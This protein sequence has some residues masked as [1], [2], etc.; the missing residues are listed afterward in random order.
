MTLT[1]NTG[2]ERAVGHDIKAGKIENYTQGKIGIVNFTEN[3]I[4]I[5]TSTNPQFSLVDFNEKRINRIIEA[6]AVD[7]I[8]SQNL[9]AHLVLSKDQLKKHR[10]TPKNTDFDFHNDM[11]KYLW[12]NVQC[13]NEYNRSISM[14]MPSFH[15]NTLNTPKMKLFH[16]QFMKILQNQTHYNMDKISDRNKIFNAWVQAYHYS[17]DRDVIKKLLY[18]HHTGIPLNPH[19]LKTLNDLSAKLY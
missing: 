11:Q 6:L 19:L 2:K 8:K 14:I 3:G 18:L 7:N 9:A 16:E 13:S 5:P 1:T 17:Y 15:Q 4:F 10:I 12:I